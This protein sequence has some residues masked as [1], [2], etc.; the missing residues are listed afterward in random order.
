MER[1]FSGLR[2]RSRILRREQTHIEPVVAAVQVQRRTF[3]ALDPLLFCR[4][5]DGKLRGELLLDPRAPARR[6]ELE[7]VDRQSSAGVERAVF[8]LPAGEL[9]IQFPRHA[10]VFEIEKS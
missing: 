1:N 5:H 9:Q 10:P 6:G 7:P 3:Q 8:T 2:Y 4:G